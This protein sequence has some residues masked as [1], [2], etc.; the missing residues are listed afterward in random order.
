MKLKDGYL[1]V[2]LFQVDFFFPLNFVSPKCHSG[3]YKI[4]RNWED[5]KY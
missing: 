4:F 2:M 1:W 5:S 3:N